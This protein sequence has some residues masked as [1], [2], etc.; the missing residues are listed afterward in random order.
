ML[1]IHVFHGDFAGEAR[2]DQ[3]RLWRAMT[4]FMQIMPA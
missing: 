3:I 1:I 4:S 2:S